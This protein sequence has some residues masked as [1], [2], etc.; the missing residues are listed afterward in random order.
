MERQ[1]PRAPC[2]RLPGTLPT[3][4]TTAKHLVPKG[5]DDTEKR[6]GD[7]QVSLSVNGKQLVGI[8]IDHERKDVL[9]AVGMAGHEED[10]ATGEFKNAFQE[11]ESLARL[12]LLD[13][14]MANKINAIW[15]RT[16]KECHNETRNLEPVVNICQSDGHLDD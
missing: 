1:L 9:L 13:A 11:N 7:F 16:C 12:F 3:K 8:E 4:E 2:Q 14:E 6:E 5:P 15:S 10:G